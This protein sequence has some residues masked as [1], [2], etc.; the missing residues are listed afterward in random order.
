V[1]NRQ[2]NQISSFES[3]EAFLAQN[4]GRTAVVPAVA[5]ELEEFRLD[6]LDIHK[7][8]EKQKTVANGKT[9][10]KLTAQDF[11]RLKMRQTAAGLSAWAHKTGNVELKSKSKYTKSDIA[12][13][14][15]TDL[16]HT[17]EALK[18]VLDSVT[19]DLSTN[20]ITKE[21]REN[22]RQAVND[23]ATS[24]KKRVVS[25]NERVDSGDEL[26]NAI[27]HA[28]ERLSEVMDNLL[29]QFVDIDPSLYN[30]YQLART[31]KNLGVRHQKPEPEPAPV[32]DPA[33][34]L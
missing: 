34:A 22:F 30:G 25:V 33:P 23:Y 28:E 21:F 29:E 9:D 31:T 5:T 20:G 16:L 17:A 14:R 19:E 10:V 1:T 3:V 8:V 27:D 7:I 18:L 6:L 12:K 2:E 11:L 13:L 32:S 15:D 24:L 26:V 4:I